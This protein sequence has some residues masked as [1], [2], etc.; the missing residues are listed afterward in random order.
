MPVTFAYDA[1]AA[2]FVGTYTPFISGKYALHV[3]RKGHNAPV[4][5]DTFYQF[6]SE[7]PWVPLHRGCCASQDLCKRSKLWGSESFFN[8]HV[9]ELQTFHLRAHDA[10][11]NMRLA[12]GDKFRGCGST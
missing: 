12:G 2:K 1:A 5:V 9:G 10:M 3:T 7:S 8:W 11:D 6:S 4:G